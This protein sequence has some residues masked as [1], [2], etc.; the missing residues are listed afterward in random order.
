[1]PLLL[2]FWILFAGSVLRAD[3]GARSADEIRR[4]E[5][6]E[7]LV[8]VR[9]IDGQP[10]PLLRATGLVKAP[11]ERVW[12]IIQNC[13]NYKHTMPRT[14]ESQELARDGNRVR[15]RMKFDMP[16]PLQ[17]LWEETDAVLTVEPGRMYKRA[18]THR[19]GDFRVNTGSWT[20]EAQPDGKSTVAT[21]ETLSEPK[22]PLPGFLLRMAQ[23][24]T[25]PDVIENLR[26]QVE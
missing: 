26:R 3:D 15:C 14:L 20:L 9:P 13:V 4:L 24:K 19:D 5:R 23:E 16:F 25:L 2:V 10:I 1:M 17:D 8:N 6:G 12:A 11:P 22:V 21:Y 7:V 18:W